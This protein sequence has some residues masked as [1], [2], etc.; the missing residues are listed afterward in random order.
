MG[1]G[2]RGKIRPP[3][4][5]QG[6]GKKQHD[7]PQHHAVSI[8]AHPGRAVQE[9]AA[10]QGQPHGQGK[11]K[12]RRHSKIGCCIRQPGKLFDSRGINDHAGAPGHSQQK[13]GDIKTDGCAP[14]RQQQ[15][16][17]HRTDFGG[18]GLVLQ[19]KPPHRAQQDVRQNSAG[20]DQSHKNTGRHGG[21]DTTKIRGVGRIKR[22]HGDHDVEF[23]ITS[24]KNQ[25]ISIAKHVSLGIAYIF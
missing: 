7:H 6:T 16:G 19:G 17:A 24:Q 25:K 18:H 13:A 9:M 5:K 8:T 4:T 21:P 22:N 3:G 2:A 15:Y 10:G 20:I 23:Q 11:C 12:Q 1:S 14:D